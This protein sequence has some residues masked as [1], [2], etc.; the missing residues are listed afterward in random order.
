MTELQLL[1]L[2]IQNERVLQTYL[3]DIHVAETESE[4][5]IAYQKKYATEDKIELIKIDLRDI[6]DKTESQN[7]KSA[8]VN[9]LNGYLEQIGLARPGA[10]LTRN[11]SMMSENMLLGLISMDIY[12][13][14]SDQSIGIHIPRY[15]EYTYSDE[16]SIEI[17]ELSDFFKNEIKIVNSIEEPDYVKLRSY[18]YGFCKRIVKKFISE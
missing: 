16:N 14:V 9:Q 5:Q 2:L 6:K 18:Y 11:Q 17:Y 7:A 1:D 4:K 15:L 13:Q 3:F 10:K 12:R 8:I